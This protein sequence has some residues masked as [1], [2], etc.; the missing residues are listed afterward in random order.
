MGD[1]QNLK[2]QAA[3]IRDEQQDYKNTALRIGKMFIDMLEQLENVL[4]NENV[5]P[6]TLTVEPTETSYKLKFSTIASDGS[7]KSREVSLPLATETKAGIMSPALLKG[8]KDQLTELDSKSILRS[9]INENSFI[10][11]YA[12]V[13]GVGGKA[14][15]YTDP[16]GNVWSYIKLSGKEGD[17]IY[18]KTYAQ[19]SSAKSYHIVDATNTIIA[20]GNSVQEGVVTIPAG[21]TD[22]YINYSAG[23]VLSKGA[24]VI[25]EES[26]VY[27]LLAN[28]VIIEDELG[29][30]SDRASS[31]AL[32]NRINSALSVDIKDL[33]GQVYDII[34]DLGDGT[35]YVSGVMPDNIEGDFT[36]EWW[37]N[38]STMTGYSAN[39]FAVQF[40]ATNYNSFVP[41]KLGSL[42]LWNNKASNNID[43]VL[44]GNGASGN[45]NN[46][47]SVVSTEGLDPSE[48][49][50]YA[51]VREGQTLKL[52]INGTLIGSKET[53]AEQ[54]IGKYIT[55]R[56]NLFMGLRVYT[57]ALNPEDIAEHI[58]PDY[59]ITLDS[60][61]VDVLA[62]NVSDEEI[63][64][65]KV[66][67]T[68]I[69][70]IATIQ[71]PKSHNVDVT[72]SF[73]GLVSPSDSPTS[74]SFYFAN[75]AGVYT[76]FSGVKI[77]SSGGLYL[78]QK[79]NEDFVLKELIK[80]SL[81]NDV[82]T[83][84][85]SNFYI[86]KGVDFYLYSDAIVDGLDRGLESPIDYYVEY[87]CN[88]GRV[89]NRGF[90]VNYGTVGTYPLAI[91]IYNLNKELVKEISTN[92]NIVDS[93]F[94]G[95]DGDIVVIGDSTESGRKYV[96][97]MYDFLL[98]NNGENIRFVGTQGKEE[99]AFKDE[100]YGGANS[101]TFITASIKKVYFTLSN[102]EQETF[103]LYSRY[104]IGTSGD[105]IEITEINTSE[106]YVSGSLTDSKISQLQPS[107]VL[108]KGGGGNYQEGSS[109]TLTYSSFEIKAQ[110]PFWNIETNQLD[111]TAYKAK[112]GSSKIKAFV[113][114]LGINDAPKNVP[115]TIQD[116]INLYNFL[117]QE[118]ERVVM[119]L[120]TDCANTQ[121][122]FGNHYGASASA[123]N[124]KYKTWMFEFRQ[125]LI[126]TFENNPSYPKAVVANLGGTIDRYYGYSQK[127][128]TVSY[129][130]SAEQTEH[131]DS[132]HP[133]A[134]AQKQG[135]MTLLGV[136][137]QMVG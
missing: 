4:P 9:G 48:I 84:I 97:P 63:T 69:E 43:S 23:N 10:K 83:I 125:A 45:F 121:S 106:G 15:I 108:Q 14:S 22:I 6:D 19:S 93:S 112:I 99:E 60:C 74:A 71:K 104:L 53:L 49:A 81:I 92:I 46:S 105:F 94:V 61:V 35:Q 111:M 68:S 102:P 39:N 7:I 36:I 24:F 62:K 118:A 52:Y 40:C 128:S 90:F 41:Y 137:R 2:N 91:K 114:V 58:N 31:Q 132:K 47:F 32:V 59:T 12:I 80:P 101:Q 89:T 78:I 122:A 134:E 103:K 55:L 11:G 88:I 27:Y 126:D 129:Y 66:T 100:G 131:T 21:G 17:K 135:A 25:Y 86:L 124:I 26:Y 67:F 37:G 77:E 113:V 82:K 57:E 96:K 64:S 75:E 85:P 20:V 95:L 54:F 18:I 79:V 16:A 117:A 119:V 76:N 38:G 42:Q 72:E 44:F 133:N 120:T 123:D 130:P 3:V 30:N 107:G 29:D 110:N 33:K 28:K 13:G 65:D 51:I 116:Y 50:F 109:D 56:N 136:I 127:T 115:N 8:V 34:A 1:F 98:L 87:N 73:G 5:Q 70:Q